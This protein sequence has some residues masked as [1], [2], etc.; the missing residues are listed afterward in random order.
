MVQCYKRIAGWKAEK[1]E[2]QGVNKVRVIAQLCTIKIV[3]AAEE[4]YAGDVDFT[5]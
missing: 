1:P 3:E 5:H 2:E 4:K